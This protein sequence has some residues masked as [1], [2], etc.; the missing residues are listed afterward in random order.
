MLV[1]TQAACKSHKCWRWQAKLA[2]VNT[3]FTPEYPGNWF[4]VCTHILTQPAG[5]CCLRVLLCQIYKAS[6]RL[7]K[8]GPTLVPRV[9]F[10]ISPLW[11]YPESWF[12]VYTFFTQI[13]DLCCPF[14]SLFQL[15]FSRGCQDQPYSFEYFAISIFTRLTNCVCHPWWHSHKMQFVWNIFSIG[16]KICLVTTYHIF[17]VAY[18]CFG[19]T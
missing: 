18:R 5:I 1:L 3:Y 2:I 12:L 11:G 10:L 14:F 16:N 8:P 13:N 15:E 4:L 7:R 19:A 6:V 9:F 17:A